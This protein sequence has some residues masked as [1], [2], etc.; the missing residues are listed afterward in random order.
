MTTG[1]YLLTGPSGKQYVGKSWS[2]RGISERWNSH[3]SSAEK[4][5]KGCR[6]LYAAIKAHGWDKF[7]KEIIHVI[8][9]ETHGENWKT[10]ISETESREIRNR[11]T[12]TPNGYNLVV[13][14]NT[15]NIEISD[16]TRALMS[17][18]SKGEN[19]PMFGKTHTPEVRKLLSEINTGRP[20]PATQKAAISKSLKGLMAGEK[21]PWFGKHHTEEAK[22]SISEAAKGRVV[23][24]E[25]RKRM[26]AAQ[27]GKVVSEETRAKRSKP[28]EQWSYDGATF[29]ATFMSI[30][31]A[32]R[33][34][35]ISTSH[36]STC[37]NQKPGHKTAG[38]FVWKFSET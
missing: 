34:T 19:N 13:G 22:K 24:V 26:G 28:V 18:R 36:I 16:E 21:H 4:G 33:R 37:A 12:M 6:Y 27:K 25:T 1:V 14:F 9:P 10:I 5:K 31:E 17:A 2:K 32:H 38:G 23:S 3:K 15:A 7:K 11:N 20:L 8:S 30:S 35:G 29:I